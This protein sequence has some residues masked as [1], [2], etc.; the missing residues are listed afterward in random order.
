MEHI[1]EMWYL[2]AVVSMA[3]ELIPESKGVYLT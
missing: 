3:D 2:G 1:Q